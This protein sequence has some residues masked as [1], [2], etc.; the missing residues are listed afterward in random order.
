[1][2]LFLTVILWRLWTRCVGRELFKL[3][4]FWKFSTSLIFFL[5]VSGDC[6]LCFIY[7]LGCLHFKGRVKL[8][9]S[10]DRERRQVFFLGVLECICLLSEVSGSCYLNVSFIFFKAVLFQ[11]SWSFTISASV[12]RWIREFWGLVKIG[13]LSIV[14]RAVFL[15]L[16]R[17]VR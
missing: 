9:F 12:L 2:Y 3:L 8:T 4:I 15:V 17:F 1:M 7:P 6:G 13:R 11:K 16:Q 14:S 10:R 5:S